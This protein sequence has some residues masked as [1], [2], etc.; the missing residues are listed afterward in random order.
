LYR[1][2]VLLEIPPPKRF[3]LEAPASA[4]SRTLSGKKSSLRAAG[5]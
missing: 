5:T 4:L 2:E 1:R 3:R